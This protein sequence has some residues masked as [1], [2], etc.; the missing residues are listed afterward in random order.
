MSCLML[1]GLCRLDVKLPPRT[2]RE[3]SVNM[4]QKIHFTII[5]I[6]TLDPFFCFYS[7]KRK[8]HRLKKNPA[9][10]PA[11][12]PLKFLKSLI[13]TGGYLSEDS[14]I[15]TPTSP[16]ASPL[17]DRNDHETHA[18]RFDVFIVLFK[19]IIKLLLQ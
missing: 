10:V 13:P 11:V 7:R 17:S 19:R 4:V 8:D 5:I 9:L 15:L 1:R 16:P 12:I 2:F 18:R 3:S 14:E 6:I